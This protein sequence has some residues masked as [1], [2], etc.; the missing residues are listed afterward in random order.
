ML[1]CY[2]NQNTIY[3]LI[4]SVAAPFPQPIQHPQFIT[5]AL[6]AANQP[7]SYNSLCYTPTAS[8]APPIWGA[9]PM[10]EQ[11]IGSND[12]TGFM[13]TGDEI[14]NAIYGNNIGISMTV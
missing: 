12:D 4:A 6:Y 13:M 1:N 7:I 9:E 8:T 2:A 14:N 10:Y 5:P 11:P 3:Y